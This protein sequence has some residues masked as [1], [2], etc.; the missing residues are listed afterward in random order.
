MGETY[1]EKEFLQPAAWPAAIC[2]APNPAGRSVKK[3]GQGLVEGI[4]GD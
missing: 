4:N 2:M 1:Q 3:A